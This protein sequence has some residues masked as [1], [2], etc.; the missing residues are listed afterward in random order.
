MQATGTD[1]HMIS[2]TMSSATSSASETSNT[3]VSRGALTGAVL[4][5]I[6]E[7]SQAILLFW[8]APT[9]D[10]RIRFPQA[11]RRRP[12]SV[13][14]ARGCYIVKTRFSKSIAQTAER[15]GDEDP[16]LNAER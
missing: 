8:L 15:N 16:R 1:D 10:L 4:S 6:T 7:Q 12:P 3:S 5:E 11:E 9:Y 14:P 2:S 13:A